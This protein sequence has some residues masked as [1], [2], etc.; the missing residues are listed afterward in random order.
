M[1]HITG[2]FVLVD[3]TDLHAQQFV[4]LAEDIVEGLENA[5]AALIQAECKPNMRRESR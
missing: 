1:F 4:E 2:T 3:G 5:P